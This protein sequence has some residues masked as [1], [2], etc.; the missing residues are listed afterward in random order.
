MV[1]QLFRY[2]EQCYFSHRSSLGKD[3]DL[4]NDY[5]YIRNGRH[6]GY[7][8][9]YGPGYAPGYAP[10]YGSPRL[11]YDNGYVGAGHVTNYAGYYRGQYY[12]MY[13]SY[14]CPLCH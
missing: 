13:G 8:L 5:G 11:R 7:G 12:S 1:L 10:R 4:R 6:G 2:N 14:K 3:Q 9:G